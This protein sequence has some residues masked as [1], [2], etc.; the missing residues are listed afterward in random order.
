MKP[1]LIFQLIHFSVIDRKYKLNFPYP[2]KLLPISE[3]IFIIFCVSGSSSMMYIFSE[4]TISCV[5]NK[6]HYSQSQKSR[7]TYP[8]VCHNVN[9]HS[10]LY[11][12]VRAVEKFLSC[13]NTSII[14]QYVNWSNFLL[15]L[16]NYVVMYKSY[17]CL[18]FSHI[19]GM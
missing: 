18:I 4:H 11:H 1:F 3:I 2:R 8:E 9:F 5:F 14:H 15:Y 6:N 16:Q 12:T 10:F 19:Y 17:N 7:H 13:H